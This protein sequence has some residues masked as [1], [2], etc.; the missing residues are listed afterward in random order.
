MRSKCDFCEADDN[1]EV[2]RAIEIPDDLIDLNDASG[3]QSGRNKLALQA[4][5][6]A[7]EFDDSLEI[8]DLDDFEDNGLE[9][10]ISK[11]YALAGTFI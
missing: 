7:D 5:D 8:Y 9:E 11:H 6:I 10:I 3:L 1:E 4:I 2:L